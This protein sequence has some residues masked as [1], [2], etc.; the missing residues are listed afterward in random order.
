MSNLLSV[1]V[2]SRKNTTSEWFE[3]TVQIA[4][5]RPTKLARRSDGSTQF[6]SKSA[7]NGAARSLAKSLGF[8]DVDFAATAT[9]TASKKSSK[10]RTTSASASV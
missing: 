5:L 4:G 3:G 8:T 10:T 6:S 2:S 1:K 9:K 7:I